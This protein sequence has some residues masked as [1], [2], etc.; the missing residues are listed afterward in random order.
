M[1]LA[2]VKPCVDPYRPALQLL[3]DPA[4]NSEYLPAP[5]MAAVL[6]VDA[7]THAYPAVHGPLHVA[8]DIAAV[9]PY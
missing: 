5:H 1:Q 4:P 6:F 8:T 2:F 7:A 3:H 9:D